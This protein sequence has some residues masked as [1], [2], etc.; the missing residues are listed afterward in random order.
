MLVS[1]SG[2]TR[3]ERVARAVELLTGWGLRPVP[4]PNAYAR[5]G[6]LAGTDEQ[7]A[8]DLNAAFADPEVRAVVA[9]RG[10]Y[11]AQRIVDW[12]GR[13]RSVDELRLAAVAVRRD[14]HPPGD[15]VGDVRAVVQLHEV[16]AQV[17]ARRGARGGEDAVGA[18]VQDGRIELD[19]WEAGPEELGEHPVRGR[20]PPVEQTGLGQD[21]RA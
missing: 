2:P 13:H 14:D 20:P 5:H 16:E 19:A 6:Y 21:E 7:R 18:D 9:T 12:H 3:P 4:G 17:D 8:A 15:G 11:G 1:P 10:G